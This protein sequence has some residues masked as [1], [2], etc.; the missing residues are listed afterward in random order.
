MDGCIFVIC[1]FCNQVLAHP[2]RN[3][4]KTTSP[5]S[6][7]QKQCKSRSEALSKSETG[8]QSMM[9]NFFNGNAL[10]RK[11]AGFGSTI[12]KCMVEEQVLKFFISGNI[13]FKQA[14][15]D[16][17]RTLISWINVKGSSRSMDRKTVRKQLSESANIAISDLRETLI[18]NTS[19]I[20]LALDIWTSRSNY[21]FMGI[22]T[23]CNVISH[24]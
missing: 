21:A 6:T 15:N 13:P 11:P 23:P 22:F 1:K 12:T 3:M 5:M 16:H 24:V 17:L 2:D 4:Q 8:S 18:T 9:N 20:S 19:K 10:S 7:H 14:D